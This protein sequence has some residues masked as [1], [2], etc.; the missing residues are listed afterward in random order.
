MDEKMQSRRRFFGTAVGAVGALGTLGAIGGSRA[1]APGSA[2][3]SQRKPTK[4]AYDVVVVGAGFAGLAASRELSRAGL[5][6]LLLEARL[7]HH[8]PLAVTQHAASLDEAFR[9]ASDKLK[10]LIEN[11]LG[12]LHNH[13]DRGSI[14]T[15]PNFIAE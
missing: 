10:R 11:T 6:V 9:G 2:D 7:A 12:R 13:R 8:Q 1:A 4:D 14:R 3:L 15:D 5:D